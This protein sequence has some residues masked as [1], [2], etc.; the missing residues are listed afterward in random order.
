MPKNL[1]HKVLVVAPDARLF[2]LLSLVETD[3]RIQVVFTAPGTPPV[4]AA[5]VLPWYEAVRHDWDLILATSPRHVSG[6]RGPV[7]IAGDTTGLCLDRM[8]A[9]LPFRARYREALGVGTGGVLVTVSS[10]WSRSSVFRSMPELCGGLLAELT[11]D[12]GRIALVVHPRIWA[13][14]RERQVRAWLSPYLD[15]G[16]ALVRPSD[17]WQGAI[18]GADWVLG[19]HGRVTALAAALGVPVTV[20][21]RPDHLRRDSPGDVLRR[22]APAL[23]HDR[24]LLSQRQTAAQQ[25][26]R[27]RR[28]ISPVIGAPG[29]TALRAAMYGLLGMCELDR[30]PIPVPLPRVFDGVLRPGRAPHAGTP[31]SARARAR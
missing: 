7:L 3:W 6:L 20:A 2:E 16:L 14:H 30:G 19:D 29:A 4:E 13:T 11:A 8:R 17:G 31:A 26:E 24:P 23:R 21:A 15:A 5:L 22:S 25:A 10:T 12:A 18:V 1:F 28:A 9:S 27:V